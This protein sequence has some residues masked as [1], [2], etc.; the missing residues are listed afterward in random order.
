MDT[1]RDIVIDIKLSFLFQNVVILLLLQLIIIIIND[2]ININILYII[3]KTHN[4]VNV[5]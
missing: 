2:F 4:Y 3:V 1:K 5:C